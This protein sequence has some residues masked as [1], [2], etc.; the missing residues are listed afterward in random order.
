MMACCNN[1]KENLL[2]TRKCYLHLNNLQ[3]ILIN[4]AYII[5]IIIII[6][7]KLSVERTVL[8]TNTLVRVAQRLLCCT[9]GDGAKAFEII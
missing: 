8:R 5:I 9:S 4:Y 6:I 7:I 2:K 1:N 3:T